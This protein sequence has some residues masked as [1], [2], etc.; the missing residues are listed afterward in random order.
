MST[1]QMEKLANNILA[2]RKNSNYRAEE[3]IQSPTAVKQHEDEV[4]R[5]QARKGIKTDRPAVTAPVDNFGDAHDATHTPGSD[6]VDPGADAEVPGEVIPAPIQYHEM[7]KKDLR[8]ECDK[9]GIEYKKKDT[10]ED[11]INKLTGGQDGNA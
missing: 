7:E 9:L 4:A 2:R 11:L 10:N 8:I 6:V 1:S 5:I 3:T